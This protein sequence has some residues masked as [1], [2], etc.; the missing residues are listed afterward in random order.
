M[1]SCFILDRIAG[2]ELVGV[3][4]R[5]PDVCAA[6]TDKS[7]DEIAAIL[8]LCHFHLIPAYR[9]LVSIAGGAYIARR[10][11]LIAA[12]GLQVGRYLVDVAD[13]AS[14]IN[15]R[16]RDPAE[17]IELV[18][19]Y[20]KPRTVD[21]P[22]AH[23]ADITGIQV[24]GVQIGGGRSIPAMRL[25]VDRDRWEGKCWGGGF[26]GSESDGRGECDRRGGCGCGGG[27]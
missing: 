23:A 26:C 19:F 13:V 27:S 14:Y 17:V 20:I 6:L 7:F 4:E 15:H 9:D 10:S 3:G 8:V 24:G 18:E 5:P 2:G 25:F 16:G 1:A 21:S 12:N 11:I 22:P